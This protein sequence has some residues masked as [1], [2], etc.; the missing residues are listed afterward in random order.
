MGRGGGITASLF[1]PVGLKVVLLES[2]L[3]TEPEWRLRRAG[4]I[5][6]SM[7]LKSNLDNFSCWG[8]YSNVV[9]SVKLV[10][11]TIVTVRFL[12]SGFP[13]FVYGDTK[14]GRIFFEFTFDGSPEIPLLR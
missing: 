9:V 4:T 14:F 3:S 8:D 13:G 11:L 10:Y 12:E 7:L 1:G 5:I 6:G 2:L